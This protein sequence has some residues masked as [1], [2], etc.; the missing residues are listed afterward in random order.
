MY[1]LESKFLEAQDSVLEEFITY[2][3]KE[4][5]QAL[6]FGRDQIEELEDYVE[7]DLRTLYDNKISYEDNISD[8][9]TRINN[10]FED[11]QEGDVLLSDIM[12][13]NQI[14]TY[15]NMPFSV[16]EE[17]ID[18]I[19]NQNDNCI[20]SAVLKAYER[21]INDAYA[22]LVCNIDIDKVKQCI[23]DSNQLYD[24]IYTPKT[25]SMKM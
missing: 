11:Y 9:I 14:F 17:A 22:E 15:D 7:G 20:N 12:P 1:N 6:D 4:K 25:T 10:R 13:Y 18:I 19:Q 16:E 8:F 2:E 3:F 23:K 21:V 24:E 5:L